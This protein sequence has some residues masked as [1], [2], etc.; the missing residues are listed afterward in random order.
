MHV[1]PDNQGKV[2]YIH[3][4]TNTEDGVKCISKTL[5]TYHIAI[6]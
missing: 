1:Y 4:D 6:S 5:D 2:I 3:F